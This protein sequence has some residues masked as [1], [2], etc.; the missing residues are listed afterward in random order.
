MQ[1]GVS[2]FQYVE[3]QPTVPAVLTPDNSYV[4][5]YL[6]SAQAY[7][8]AGW[9]SK[10]G[11]LAVS[12]AVDSSIDNV[13]PTQNLHQLT[14]F[15]KNT[16]CHLGLQI[17]LTDWLPARR[18]DTLR[19]TLTYTVM[20]D[21]PF[22]TLVDK[23]DQM[24]LVSKLSVVRP[25]LGAAVQVSKITGNLLSFLLQEGTEK[26]VF[27]L[28]VDLPMQSTQAGYYAIYGSPDQ[29]PLPKSVWLD[30]LGNLKDDGDLL[31]RLSYALINITAL[32][33]RGEEIARGE[34]WWELL[35]TAKDEALLAMPMSETETQQIKADWIKSL[36]Q[37]KSLARK[38]RTYVWPE[39][40][41]II[42]TA[43]QE[44]SGK[45]TVRMMEATLP[46]PK[47]LQ[48]VL[49][50]ATESELFAS[51]RDYKDALDIS[52]AVLQEYGLDAEK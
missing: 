16:P 23:I 43:H 40:E 21:T 10:A 39:L 17:A 47:D 24:N 42:N 7:F 1:T 30:K 52:K 2:Q 14:G 20:R 35:Q 13:P 9:L 45:L 29:V 22:K 25:E 46:L 36:K 32:P 6:Q 33:R 4:M 26:D 51:V 44:V 49:G 15:Q 27:D 11:Y 19:L 37:V 5:L 34:P 3:K 28:T 18:T 48:D 38:E 31:P 8:S 41:A 12:S 50:V